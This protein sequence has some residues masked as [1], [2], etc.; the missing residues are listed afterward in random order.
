VPAVTEGDF[1]GRRVEMVDA[2]ARV[3]SREVT[4]GPPALPCHEDGLRPWDNRGEVDEE[5]L[6]GASRRV[7]GQALVV[8]ESAYSLAKKCRGTPNAY[9]QV[10][11]SQSVQRPRW[12]PTLTARPER[13]P[14]W[15][16]PFRP[17]PTS[18]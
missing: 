10:A 13:H 5:L 3:R 9:R 12:G 8:S 2:R 15:Y 14:Y 4:E 18:Q 11:T 6:V 1:T 7:R 17:L 16:G